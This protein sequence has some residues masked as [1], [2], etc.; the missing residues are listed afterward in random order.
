MRIFLPFEGDKYLTEITGKSQSRMEF[1][2][3]SVPI[4]TGSKRAPKS[5]DN[6]SMNG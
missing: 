2:A 4:A 3:I 5:F 1:P 6:L